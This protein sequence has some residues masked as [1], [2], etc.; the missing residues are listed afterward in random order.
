MNT[1]D[2]CKHWRRESAWGGKFDGIGICN[3]TK[4]VEGTPEQD[5]L[6]YQY[7]EGGHQ[8]TGPKFGCIHHES[9]P[10]TGDPLKPTVIFCPGFT[11]EQIEAAKRLAGWIT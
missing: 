1:C 11:P 9:K 6:G 7:E 5:G 3:C 10:P 4:V 2:S 8:Q